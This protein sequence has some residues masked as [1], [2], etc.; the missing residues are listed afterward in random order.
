[1]RVTAETKEATR[2]AILQSARRLFAEQGFDAT[3][4]RDIARD[5]EIATRHAVQLLRHQ[6]SHRRLHGRTRR[7]AIRWPP[8]TW[9]RPDTLEEGAVLAGRTEPAKAEAAAKVFAGAPDNVAQSARQRCRRRYGIA[10]AH[11]SRSG[12]AAGR[13]A[14]LGELSAA[15]LQLYWTL[16]TGVLVFWAND[17]SP[18]Q[19]DTL[20]LIDD[21]LNMF[22][23]WLRNQ[24]ASDNKRTSIRS[25]S[26]PTVAQLMNALPEPDEYAP[27]TS[28]RR[29][30]V[31]QALAMRPCRSAG[32]AGSAAR[33]APGQDR[34]RL[35][36]LLAPR[37]V[38]ERRRATSGCWPRRTGARPCACWTR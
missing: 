24:S 23:A 26:M 11:A 6:G 16:Y 1:M 31:W 29:P 17:K 20:A 9:S 14:R 2:E 22:V 3:T 35:P 13:E 28:A 21:S 34:R 7:L 12:R 38:Q 37:L 10:S 25:P 30:I 19:E 33:H 36:V 32:S 15:A 4:T 5:A 8:T 18:K 27:S